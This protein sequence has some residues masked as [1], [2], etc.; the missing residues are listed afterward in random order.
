LHACLLLTLSV[1]FVACLF[2]CL[3]FFRIFASTFRSLVVCLLV[4]IR[5]SV[6]QE[7]CVTLETR[8]VKYKRTCAV[9]NTWL[10]V[11]LSLY[12]ELVVFIP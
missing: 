3:L 1:C 8:K 11:V 5:R 12:E 4:C 9:I 2:V 10:Y 6:S 7:P